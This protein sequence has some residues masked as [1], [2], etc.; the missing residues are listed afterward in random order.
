MI[1]PLALIRPRAREVELAQSA[2]YEYADGWVFRVGGVIRKSCTTAI[3]AGLMLAPV[4]AHADFWSWLVGPK[5]YEDCAEKAAREAK[6]KDDL[7]V[8]L[9]SCNSNFSG[10]RKPTG[11]YTLYDERQNRSFDTAG[12]NPTPNESR[13]IESQYSEY[14]AAQAELEQREQELQ[15]ERAEAARRLNSKRE[16]ENPAPRRR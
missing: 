4:T 7:S 8:L 16:K 11:G 15:E 13:Y 12:P 9:S 3:L 1:N 10:R 6:S 5:D 14:L 2:V